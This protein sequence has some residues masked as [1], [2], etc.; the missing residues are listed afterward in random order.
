MKFQAVL[1]DI[2]SNVKDPAP[3]KDLDSEQLA[4]LRDDIDTHME[5]LVDAAADAENEDDEDNVEEG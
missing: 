3:G 4:E 5:N 1:D 2:K